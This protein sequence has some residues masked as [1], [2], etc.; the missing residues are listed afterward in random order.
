[1]TK[2]CLFNGRKTNYIRK[3][4]YL[5][6]RTRKK[7]NK[8]INVKIYTINLSSVCLKIEWIL[9]KFINYIQWWSSNKLEEKLTLCEIQTNKEKNWIIHSIRLSKVQQ[10]IFIRIVTKWKKSSFFQ[11]FIV[12]S[13]T[14]TLI[15]SKH[16]RL[17]DRVEQIFSWFKWSRQNKNL[18][19]ISFHIKIVRK[20]ILQT[21]CLEKNNFIRIII[22]RT[23]II[24][25][26]V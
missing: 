20:K 25:D 4:N 10:W 2:D 12:C 15:T 3:F 7:T 24:I 19:R 8:K 23:M 5:T 18:N 22:S 11:P 9:E 6:N 21:F 16:H 17:L 1:M 13:M 26:I 14:S